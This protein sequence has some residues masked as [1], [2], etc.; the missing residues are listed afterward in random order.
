MRNNQRRLAVLYKVRFWTV[1]ALLAPLVSGCAF[2]NQPNGAGLPSTKTSVSDSVINSGVNRQRL[3]IELARQQVRGE[4]ID[5]QRAV[6]TAETAAAASTAMGSKRA[7]TESGAAARRQAIW[8]LG[9]EDPATYLAGFELHKLDV[10]DTVSR[11]DQLKAAGINPSSWIQLK[12]TTH[13]SGRVNHVWVDPTNADRLLVGTDGDGIWRSLDAGQS[14][15]PLTDPLGALSIEKIVSSA[16]DPT[17]LYAA[18]GSGRGHSQ[19]VG[20]G[21]LKSTNRGES[22][23]VLPATSCTIVPFT[24]SGGSR[25]W[26]KIY[27]LD[28]SPVNPNLAM[29]ATFSG[30]RR[31]TDGGQTWAL[32]IPTI[33]FDYI[34][35]VVFNPVDPSKIVAIAQNSVS[36][37]SVDGGVTWSPMT[38]AGL[39]GAAGGEGARI[40]F[41]RTTNG[42]VFL[43]AANSAR[44]LVLHRS[45]DNG[46]TWQF[47]SIV[48]YGGTQ[49]SSSLWYTGALWVDPTDDSRIV[50][51]SGWTYRSQDRGLTWPASFCCGWADPTSVVSDTGYNGVG[52]KR[53]YVS[54]DGGLYR[55]NDISSSQPQYYDPTLIS[56]GTS[57]S[58][59]NANG[60]AV[61]QNYVTAG[62]SPGPVITGNQD[63]GVQT[64]SSLTDTASRWRLVGAGD[65]TSVAVD[66]SNPSTVYATM[67]QAAHIFRSDDGGATTTVLCSVWRGAATAPAA[68]TAPCS[69]SAPFV[70]R[71][72]LD[73]LAPTRLYV[74]AKSLWRTDDAKTTATPVWT[75]IF[76]GQSA[77]YGITALAVSL[78][79]PN[80]LWFHQNTYR[81][82]IIYRTGNARAAVPVFVATSP[83]PTSCFVN[84]IYASRY[85]LSTAWVGCAGTAGF[86]D[87]T[88]YRTDDSGAS[89]TPVTN[90][91]RFPIHS[92]SQHPQN[93]N[94]L[95][96][97]T[98]YG[99]YD[100]ED[101]GAT[102]SA[103]AEG[104]G[105]VA[106]T[107]INWYSSTDMLVGTYGRNVWKQSV[108]G[109][110]TPPVACTLDIDADTKVLPTTD[111][112][113]ILRRMLSLSGEGLRAQ[114]HNPLGGRTDAVAMAAL[115]DPMITTKT[116]DIDGDGNVTAATDGVLLLRALLGFSGTAVT[117]GALGSGPKTRGDWPSIRQY[118]SGTCGLGAVLAP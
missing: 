3:Q 81:S 10:A 68:G 14:W 62:I 111:G 92:I 108:V 75:K 28:V 74:G 15:V 93:P 114:A 26:A 34:R 71:I 57:V 118:L 47:V 61:T 116:L 24:C 112:L 39:N 51:G 64:L 21:L 55:Y 43:L 37:R 89:W 87:S 30:L 33:N 17:T 58:Y 48:N 19:T 85:A 49:L 100:S 1:T 72:A 98:E 44:Q 18:S 31:T 70:S 59:L 42:R 13:P 8:G 66:P 90:A 40:A 109:S 73:P 115:I 110:P 56:V 77:D 97:G 96:I 113:L 2:N 106:V 20:R 107:S 76:T 84:T 78:L 99:L 35:D 22:W 9:P 67:Q 88:L 36:Y 27:A 104:P 41:S 16:S 53:V 32:V 65:G 11:S 45:D 105:T 12:R 101:G 79:D 6:S 4:V 25:D 94:L 5:I 91:P 54:D 60:L 7:R 117:N 29:V 95:Y 23:A 52:N 103:G 86:S 83:L 63:V 46:A 80:V 69:D 82:F 50:A 38:V 102:W